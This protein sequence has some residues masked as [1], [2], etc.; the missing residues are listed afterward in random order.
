METKINYWTFPALPRNDEVIADQIINDLN[1]FAEVDLKMRT[2]KRDVLEP[3][4][5]A[6]YLIRQ[7]TELSLMKIGKI[8]GIDHSSVIH[9][10]DV[11]RELRKYDKVFAE[12]WKEW[13]EKRY[14]PRIETNFNTNDYE[15][16]NKIGEEQD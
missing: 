3:R 15:Q 5:V 7:N 13:L 14:R 1:E 4:Q 9:S 11:V 2:R 8:L 16:Q 12:R 10:V 6:C